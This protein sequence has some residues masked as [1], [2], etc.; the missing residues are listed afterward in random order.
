MQ[1]LT[2]KNTRAMVASSNLVNLL[3]LQDRYQMR[4]NL[5]SME[6][7]SIRYA[8]WVFQ[9]M[10]PSMLYTEQ[11]IILLTLP[12]LG[13]LRTWITQVNYLLI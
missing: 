3:I 9:K 8:K 13:T 2:L 10:L 1:S 4:L 7:W 11:E 5:S 6:S 12:S